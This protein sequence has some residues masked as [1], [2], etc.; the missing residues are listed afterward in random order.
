[1][2]SGLKSGVVKLSPDHG[3]WPKRYRQ[4]MRRLRKLTGNARYTLEHIG[5]TA[6]PGLD[7]KPIIDMAMRIPSFK[8]LPLWI[9]RLEK[10][11]YVYKGEYGLPGRHFFVRGNPVTH[12]LHLVIPGSEHWAR[13]LLFRDYLRA[14]PIEAKRY[15]AAKLKLARK[16]PTNRDAYTRAKTPVINRLLVRAGIWL[17]TADRCPSPR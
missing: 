10:A 5:S 14:N 8:R 15:D 9:T 12:H 6:I 16:Y 2:N 7:A 3:D 13:W 4:E 1:V 17:K 11:G